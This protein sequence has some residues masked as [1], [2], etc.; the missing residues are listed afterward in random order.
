M[1]IRA[2]LLRWHRA[3]APVR[4]WETERDPYVILVREVMSQQTQIARVVEALPRFLE[5]FPDLRALAAAT[6]AQVI[7]AWRGLGYNRRALAL[8]RAART[9]LERHDGTLPGD[10]A[11]LRALPGIGPYTAAAVAVFAHG[12]RV[13]VVDTNVRRVIGRAVLG[14]PDARTA[15]VEA[16]VASLLHGARDPRR[17]TQ[18]LID[19]GALRCGA[20]SPTCDDCPLRT[21]CV[22]YRSGRVHPA[23]PK[24]QGRFEGSMRQLRGAVIDALREQPAGM[25]RAHLRRRLG[26]PALATLEGLERDGLLERD[27]ARV[28][29]PAGF[30]G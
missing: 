27:G 8:H 7:E 13:P 2:H 26:E 19:L 22:A 24:G 25:T 16:G 12:A 9:C 5:R 20:R 1:S 28:R 30:G 3:H 6:P 11:G 15:D 29:L 18:A 23:R 17:L 4:G 10:V 14:D 21:V